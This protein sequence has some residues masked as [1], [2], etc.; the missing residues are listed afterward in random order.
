[1][2]LL[3]VTSVAL[4]MIAAQ[5]A[6]AGGPPCSC[7]QELFADYPGPFDLYIALTHQISCDDEGEEELWFG[8]PSNSTRPQIC[9]SNSCEDYEEDG[10]RAAST[11]PGHG[12]QLVGVKA[13]DVFR[14][15]I[16]SA[17]RKM[18]GLEYGT[19]T[20]HILP[21]KNLPTK[22]KA[23]QD[24]IV[25][26]IP[27]EI[28]IKDSRLD[29]KTYYLCVQLDSAEGLPITKAAFENGKPGTGSQL[30]IK[31]RVKSGEVRKGLVWLK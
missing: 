10:G 24:M 20:Y 31:Y 25:M 23:T 6:L 29:G 30:N 22:L 19:P 5:P 2:R 18:P 27:M 7:I 8:N 3:T 14:V 12:Q 21:R 28:H 13:W 4:L 17:A 1:M 9:E 11:F 16:E 26:A 15:G